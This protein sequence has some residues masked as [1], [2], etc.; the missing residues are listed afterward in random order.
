MIKL[1]LTDLDG[2][3]LNSKGDYNKEDFSNI[4]SELTK[5]NIAFGAVTGKQ[6]E[7]VEELFGDLADK[8]WILGDSA[9][10]IKH[11]GKFEFESLIPNSKGLDI[12]SKLEG[13]QADQT[14][15]A[16]TTQAAVIAD[17][18]QLLDGE[19][20]RRS[21][22]TI[23]VVKDFSEI[24]DD[25]VKITV[26]DRKKRCF[27][28]F[29]K[30]KGEQDNFYIVASEAAWIDI[31]SKGIHKGTTVQKLQEILA[32]SSDETM[33]FGDGYNDFELLNQAQE[34]YAMANAFD[35]VKTHAKHIAPP[36]D[37]NGVLQVI[38]EK[39]LN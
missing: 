1:I 37:E 22:A 3:F 23:N 5:K 39:V 4:L 15:I 2:T 34:S 6:T 20:V 26:F 7:R 36:N 9:S 38:K 16:C 21:Y 18:R 30:I 13:I 33:A 27:D 12:I 24:T 31:T 32:V 10:R 14:I 8:I 35:E 17:R 11:A 19:L 28:T 29:E 25:F